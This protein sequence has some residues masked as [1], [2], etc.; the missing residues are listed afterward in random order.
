MREGSKTFYARDLRHNSTV[1]EKKLWDQ[2]RNRQ[3]E[4]HKIVRQFPVGPYIADFVCR[5]KMLVIE[6]DGQTH[7]TPEEL[8]YDKM[9]TAFLNEQGY[10]VIR[11][12]NIEVLDG[13]DEILVLISEALKR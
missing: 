2:L 11:F 10:A 6:L 5:E 12:Q 7:S 9:R 13:M 4:N 3:L 8:T 1:A